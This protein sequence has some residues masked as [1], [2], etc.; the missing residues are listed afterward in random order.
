MGYVLIVGATS[1]IAQEIS[2]ELATIGKDLILAGRDITELERQKMDLEFR[3]DISV[4]TLYFNAVDMGEDGGISKL[5]IESQDIDGAV[6]TYGYLGDQQ[7][8]ELDFA[9]SK[10]IIDINFTST[11]M[12]L[13]E[14]A[15]YFESR[16]N[17]FICVLSSVAGD[18][19]RQS[20]YVY[21]AAKGGLTVFL[22]GL[23]NRLYTKN[24]RVITVKPGFVDTKM[25]YGQ[26]N[27]P[28][29]ISA[30]KAAQIIV[31][32][33]Y[34]NKDVI[35]VPSFWGLIMLIIRIIPEKIF[36]RLKL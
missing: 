30:Q 20:N 29:I 6:L 34:W 4:Q 3:Y 2:K 22:Q 14:L 17:G 27:S 13:H 8:A 23:R 12:L 11:V 5:E 24:V 15:K 9:E 18:R 21:G 7:K 10:K 25:T 33:I 26:V 28:L 16:C 35:Y 19:G 1:G 32:T 36:K 31:K